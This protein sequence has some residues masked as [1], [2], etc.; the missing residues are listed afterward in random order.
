[1]IAKIFPTNF[2]TRNNLNEKAMKVQ[3]R[4]LPLIVIATFAACSTDSRVRQG[5][6][7]PIRASEAGMEDEWM[8]QRKTVQYAQAPRQSRPAPP[9]R[10]PAPAPAPARSDTVCSAPTGG[11]APMTIIM[12]RD[13]AFGD[14]FT[15]EINVN[16]AE[17]V[18]NVVVTDTI[19]NGATFVRSEPPAEQQGD[20]LRWNL[21][22][23]DK[24]QSAT[25][26]V[27]LRADKE[28]TLASCA[29]IS[30]DPRT[31]GQIFI[32]KPMIALQKTGPETAIL[33]STIT[34]L[35]TVSNKGTMVAKNVVIVDDLPDGLISV[36][37]QHRLTLDVGDLAPN[38][39]KT[40]S[41][42]VKAL[43]RGKFC[44]VAKV[45]SS[46]AGEA[47][48]EACTTVLQPGLKITKEGTKEQ[49]L[50]RT[51]TYNIV[52]S[53]TGDTPLAGVTVTDPAPAGTTITAAA[54]GA[55]ATASQAVW[56]LGTLQ[57]GE[58]K[59]L[60][61]SVT[62]TIAGNHCNVATVATSEGLTE[63]AQACTMWLGVGALLLETLDDPDPIQ[64]GETTTYKV[65]VTNQGTA[66]D[67]NI[68]VVVEFS[69]EIDPV[70]ASN[71]GVVNGKTVTF[72]AFD[73]LASKQAFEYSIV[74]KGVKVGDART[75]F[76]RTSDGIPAPTTS[77]ESTRVY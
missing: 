33:G 9:P 74:G 22:D 63:N 68:K 35:I 6:V 2:P 17:C 4:I 18:G 47:Q 58:E 23:M 7:A 29:I 76:T 46:N 52:I 38:E 43:K 53:N 19:P 30:A 77:E 56:N 14:T 73:R 41:G 59:A 34:Y 8:A 50:T 72:P 32:G 54:P 66:D 1:M 31:C 62:S 51:A 69:P 67:T 71:G 20:R 61:V 15:Y 26:K 21:G 64:V 28:G 13:A 16:A 37:D 49:F 55:S 48:A 25:I 27:S 60:T 45:T 40:L 11:P 57:P 12:P 75:K 3:S 24:G 5:D 65:R 36:T 39:S 44:N 10:A 70:S 42:A